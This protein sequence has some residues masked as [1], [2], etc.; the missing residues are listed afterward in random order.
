MPIQAG[1]KLMDH[2][3]R[4]TR[5]SEG[6]R[7]LLSLCLREKISAFL[8]CLLNLKNREG[9]I[10]VRYNDYRYHFEIRHCKDALYLNANA[11]PRNLCI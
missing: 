11:L 8:T 3:E 2:L 9:E 1:A 7:R 5:S 4:I 10:P 6:E